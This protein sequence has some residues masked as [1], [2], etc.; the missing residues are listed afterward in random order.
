[1]SK[2]QFEL[3]YC[4]VM[5]QVR[6]TSCH[7]RCFLYKV[8]PPYQLI[9]L[10]NLVLAMCYKLQTMLMA[11]FSVGTA[12]GFTVFMPIFTGSCICVPVVLLV[13]LNV[14]LFVFMFRNLGD[15]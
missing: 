12:L 4:C 14:K 13:F 5:L 3:V 8:I 7:V 1:M 15:V 2:L 9:I 11:I 6:Y 10:M